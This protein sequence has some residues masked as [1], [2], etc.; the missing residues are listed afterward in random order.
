MNICSSKFIRLKRGLMHS[1]IVSCLHS[2]SSKWVEPVG[3]LTEINVYN[4]ATKCKVPFV[5]RNIN[6]AS[7]Y[8]C[9][10]TVYDSAHIGHACCYVKFDIIRRIL[11]NFFN[12]NVVLVMGITDIDDKIIKRALT[13]K[14][15]FRVV[16]SKYENEFFEDMHA[17]NVLP[18]TLCVRVTDVV[19]H[20]IEFVKSI[21]DKGLAYKTGDGSVYFDTAEFKQYGK[22]CPVNHEVGDVFTPKKSVNDFALWKASKP[23][24][25]F[26]LSPWGKGRPGWHIECSTIASCV[27]GSSVDIHSGGIDLLFP[28]HENEESQS[29][30]YHG[31]EQWV[32][33]WL[34][35]GLLHLK[36]DEKMSKSLKNT[37]SIQEL[38]SSHS[39][40]HF[41]M[42]CL[43]SR[44][45]NDVEYTDKTFAHAKA[46]YKKIQSF[47]S[48]CDSYIKGIRGNCQIQESVLLEKLAYTRQNFVTALADDFD[49]AK[50]L[51]ILMDFISDIN[52]M[53]Q[54]SSQ[55]Y[56]SFR[57]PG[58]IAA[59]SSFVQHVTSQLGLSF[60]DEE[61]SINYHEDASK[62][63]DMVTE[64]RSEV[65]KLA[66]LNLKNKRT[67]ANVEHNKQLLVACDQFRDKLNLVGIEIKDHGQKSSWNRAKK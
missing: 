3:H 58:V 63:M 23:D 66:L 67:E 11:Q 22:L 55:E 35:T 26:W 42:Y 32:N 45:R 43:L 34:H 30:A 56:V 25:P 52:V 1:F 8:M 50:A 15:D 6:Y 51:A 2:N 13:L 5:L 54:A 17:L 60:L 14:E 38:L 21:V 48:D 61:K 31:V 28:H 39:A 27:L 47:F 40:D 33:Y 46:V 37:I 20:I 24:E 16:S 65:R 62:I 9:G 41:R 19:P 59:A 53:L 29:C 44:Y 57:N 49:T 4:S 64:F 10:P 7:W 12:I 36:N 18:P